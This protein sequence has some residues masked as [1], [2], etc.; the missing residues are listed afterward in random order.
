ML[1]F[2]EYLQIIAVVIGKD[3][4]ELELNTIYI[5]RYKLVSEAQT[6]I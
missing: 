5:K 1:G 2:K 6:T 3:D 4:G